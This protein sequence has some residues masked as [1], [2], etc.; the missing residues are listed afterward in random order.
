[1]RCALYLTIV[2]AGHPWPH[3]RGP[4]CASTSDDRSALA[5]E[6]RDMITVSIGKTTRTD[7]DRDVEWQ[8]GRSASGLHEATMPRVKRG[9][10]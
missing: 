8:L 10:R 2:N 6:A 7:E 1:V 4:Q 5:N 9:Q 3:I